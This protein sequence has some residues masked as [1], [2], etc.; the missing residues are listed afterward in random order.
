MARNTTVRD[1]HR[2]HIARG[3][4]PCALCGQDID[5]TLP[6]L[7]P[8]AFTVDHV[9]PLSKGGTDELFNPD[10]TPQ[11]QAAHRRCNLGKYNR[12]DGEDHRR[13]FV[14]HLTW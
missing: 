1:R 14:T 3:K 8:W 4:P 6:H 5:Y 11:K 2:R 12:H 13:R 9:I 7:D 10:G